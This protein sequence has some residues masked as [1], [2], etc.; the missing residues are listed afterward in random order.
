MS[1]F[2]SKDK[3][4]T[5]AVLSQVREKELVQIHKAS[6]NPSAE[7]NSERSREGNTNGRNV[8]AKNTKV[9]LG[10]NRRQGHEEE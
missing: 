5:L 4:K 2:T 9:R 7:G 1:L 8:N 10:R 6:W 3:N